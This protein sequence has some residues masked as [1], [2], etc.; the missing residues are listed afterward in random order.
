MIIIPPYILETYSLQLNSYFKQEISQSVSNNQVDLYIDALVEYYNMIYEQQQIDKSNIMNDLTNNHSLNCA[1]MFVQGKVFADTIQSYIEY[2]RNEVNLECFVK[3]TNTFLLQ[4]IDS[5]QS[6]E[7]M[8][9]A[10]LKEASELTMWKVIYT[11]TQFFNLLYSRKI[12]G[13]VQLNN[14]EFEQYVSQLKKTNAS[15]ARLN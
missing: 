8:Q 7:A 5:I 3:Q 6:N 1:Q 15:I 11:S 10:S 13:K 12:D 2:I 9:F 14:A 4:H